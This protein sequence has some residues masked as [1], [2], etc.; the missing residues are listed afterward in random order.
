MI[1]GDLVLNIST[2]KEK[3]NAESSLKMRIKYLMKFKIDVFYNLLRKVCNMNIWRVLERKN[4]GENETWL[5]KD[6]F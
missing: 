6:D 1:N 2:I 3:K 4:F 5:Y